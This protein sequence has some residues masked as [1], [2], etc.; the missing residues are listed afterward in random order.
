MNG[1]MPYAD[2]HVS[3]NFRKE[4]VNNNTSFFECNNLNYFILAVL[5]F[6]IMACVLNFSSNSGYECFRVEK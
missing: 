3:I 2:L 4:C 6:Q 1:L 5:F